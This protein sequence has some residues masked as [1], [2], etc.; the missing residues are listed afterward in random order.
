MK[1]DAQAR[2]W[3]AL[4]NIDGDISIPTSAGMG[5]PPKYP[6]RDMQVGDSFFTTNDNVRQV[7]TYARR[8][9][10]GKFTTRRWIEDGVRGIRVWKVG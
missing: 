10:I 5:R 1:T 4:V 9:G 6:L 3:A 7:V 8:H 2:K